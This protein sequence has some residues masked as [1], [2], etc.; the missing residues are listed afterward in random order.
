[1]YQPNPALADS[2]RRAYAVFDEVPPRGALQVCHCNVCMS[3]QTELELIATPLPA[4]SRELLAEYTNSAHGWN[5]IVEREFRYFL[6]RY[7]DLIAADQPPDHRGPE[8]C[9]NRLREADWRRRW[10]PAEI[11]LLDEFFV[12]LLLDNLDDLRLEPHHPSDPVRNIGATLTLAVRA[13][14]S[15]ESL[16]AA[17]HECR[18]PGAA[19]HLAMLRSD[20][21]PAPTGGWRARNAFLDDFEAEALQIGRFASDPAQVPRLEQAL[22]ALDDAAPVLRQIIVENLT[23]S[24]PRMP[25][26]T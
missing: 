21:A 25:H 16:L 9:L 8:T 18:S 11:A 24:L 22:L 10:A 13:G 26:P 5:D 20:L 15:L 19:V 4:I 17:W 1:M 6:P 3:P 7:L 14:A 12:A 2:V 23:L